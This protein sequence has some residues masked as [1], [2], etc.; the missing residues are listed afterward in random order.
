MIHRQNYLDVR[1]YL[2]YCDQVR[3][4]SPETLA[5]NRAHLRHLLEWAGETPLPRSR[6]LPPF[7]L[8]ILTA[9]A[10]GHTGKLS[11]SSIKKGLEAAR[12]FYIWS[13]DQW[14]QRYHSIKASWIE[15][16]TPPRGSRLE[17]HLVDHKA[18]TLEDVFKITRVPVE[19]LRQQRAQVAAA[20]LFLSGMR[21]DA[22]ATIPISCVDI[23]KREI[24]QLP[25]MGVRTKNRK[26]ALTYLLDIPELLAVVDRWDHLVRVHPTESL[27]YSTIT[28]DGMTLTITTPAHTGRG[29]LVS[30]DLR[31]LCTLAGV[32][33]LSP[34]KLRHGFAVHA[35][36]EARTMAELKA[37]SQN[38]MHSSVTITDSIYA[39]LVNDDVRTIIG[40]LGKSP[41]P[42]PD[43]TAAKLD[44]LLELIK[45]LQPAAA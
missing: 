12:H 11:P 43:S 40:A 19:T 21:A 1:A 17:S 44:Q 33:Y 32:P 41:L 5:R 28:R 2:K 26:A 29:D 37:I 27:W 39:R 20:M 30:R 24:R 3:Q 8:Y 42:A 6:Q 45:Q 34:H 9:R 4:N 10:D 13:R 16:L 7:P 18:Y 15:Q 35:L 31:P 14:P 38:L 25:E 36:K 23:G 22:L